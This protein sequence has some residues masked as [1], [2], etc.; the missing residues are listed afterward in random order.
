MM[1]DESVEASLLV[2]PLPWQLHGCKV[3]EIINF[4][5]SLGFLYYEMS[6]YYL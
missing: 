1:N 2:L 5:M 6:I 4:L 3:N